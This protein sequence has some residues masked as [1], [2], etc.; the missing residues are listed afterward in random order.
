V[1]ETYSAF[2]T[3]ALGRVP[4]SGNGIVIVMGTDEQTGLP[5]ELSIL[6]EKRPDNSLTVYAIWDHMAGPTPPWPCLYVEDVPDAMN[7]KRLRIAYEE[8]QVRR[9]MR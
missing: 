9:V 2:V 4:I 5:L 8:P 6:L 1:D 3:T 7:V